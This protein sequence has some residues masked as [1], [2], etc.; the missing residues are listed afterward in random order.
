MSD[1]TAIQLVNATKT[2]GDV[3]ANDSITLDLRNREILALLG[4]NGSGKSTLMNMLSGIYMP[5]NGSIF[6]RGRRID[7]R[8]PQDAKKFGIGM[9]HQHF[10]LVDRM[11]ARENIILGEKGR[12][13]LNKTKTDKELTRVMEKYGLFVDLGKKAGDMTVSEKQTLEIIKVLYSGAQILILDE[14]TAVLTP[15]EI[16]RLFMILRK[17]RNEG[18]SII[19]ITHKLNEVMQISDRVSV[20]RKGRLVATVDTASTHSI[21]LAE[22]MMGKAMDFKIDRPKYGNGKKILE[23]RDLTVENQDKVEK[24]AGIGFDLYEGEILGVAGIANSGQK[25]L[26]ESIAGLIAVKSGEIMYEGSDIVGKNPR[27]ILKLGISMSFIPEDRLGMGLVADMDMVDNLMLKDYFVQKGLFLDRRY[28]QKKAEKI[29][30]TF[31]ITTTGIHQAVKKMSG[32]NIQKVLL[33]RELDQNPHVLI[34]AYPIRGLDIGSTYTVF[35]ILNRQKMEGVGVIFIGED[36]D[37]LMA[38]S[39]RILVLCGGKVT[40]IVD[41][42][43]VT[44]DQLGLLMTGEVSIYA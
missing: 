22:M 37:M 11:T 43:N 27:E 34:T 39:D 7:I 15:Q 16:N 10:K 1:R 20:L 28:A 30:R 21:E 26:C 18:H 32:G 24:L 19:I 29:I 41:A 14:P 12:S 42:K 23:C 5:D 44:R 13:F 35:D 40:G 17:M 38:L 8:S 3:I 31:D 6:L 36:L 25:E 9:I 4:E 2:F 33:G